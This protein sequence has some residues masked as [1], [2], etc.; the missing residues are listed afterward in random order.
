VFI[1]V[2]F[3]LLVVWQVMHADS[4]EKQTEKRKC[5]R[6]SAICYSVLWGTFW[7]A[8]RFIG[9]E[10][11]KQ[12]YLTNQVPRTLANALLVCDVF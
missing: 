5:M 2:I 4:L 1:W 12:E 10:I 8:E 9:L 3:K 6:Y 7:I 11:I